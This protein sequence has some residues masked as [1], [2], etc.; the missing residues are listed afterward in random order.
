MTEVRRYLRGHY[1]PVT[2]SD[3]LSGILVCI[4]KMGDKSGVKQGL[5]SK[6]VIQIFTKVLDDNLLAVIGE[7]PAH[8]VIQLAESVR[9]G[10]AHK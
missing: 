5:H 10:G 7:V 1:R 6:G 8:P 9:Y 4:E 3:G 2:H